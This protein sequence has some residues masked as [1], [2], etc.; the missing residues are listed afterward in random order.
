[1][2]LVE[3]KC[4]NCGSNL[5]FNPELDEIICNYCGAKIMIDDEATKLNRIE[6]IKLKSRK[7][8]HEQ[9]MKELKEKD[10]YKYEK[11]KKKM[12]LALIILLCLFCVVPIIA[13]MNWI[14]TGE[15]SIPGYKS[16]P[17]LSSYNSLELGMSYHE[18]IEIL[19]SEGHLI[20]EN[21]MTKVYV[22]YDN[23]CSDENDCKT[24]IKLIFNND[25]LIERYENGLK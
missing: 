20:E 11:D 21:S 22:W 24:I 13:S 19:K 8:N 6:N 4:K 14:F 12:K 5:K 1:M 25:I 2:D 10:N 7:V 9:Y 3:L 18:C 16:N 15:F 17:S 23:I